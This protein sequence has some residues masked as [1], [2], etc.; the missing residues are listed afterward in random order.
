MSRTSHPLRS[1]VPSRLDRRQFNGPPR[2]V[3]DA[4][5]TS[6]S[7]TNKLPPASVQADLDQRQTSQ[8]LQDNLEYHASKPADSKIHHSSSRPRPGTTYLATFLAN[9]GSFAS[10]S[11]SLAELFWLV[12]REQPED[13]LDRR[14]PIDHFFPPRCRRTSPLPRL[15]RGYLRLPLS[16]TS[17]NQAST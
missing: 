15:V 9:A 4:C 8:Q 5:R 11:R 12:F 7:A 3:S 16:P 10:A 17:M 2:T 6:T 14:I 1:E 13:R